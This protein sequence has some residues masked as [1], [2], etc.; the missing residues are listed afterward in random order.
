V[1]HVSLH[2]HLPG[3][4][5]VVSRDP[6]RNHAH[7][8]IYVALRDAC[9]AARSQLEAID[10]LSGKGSRHARSRFESNPRRGEPF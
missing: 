3:R 6:E 4:E 10:Q 8:D 2:L 1:F 7:E 9:D 5:I